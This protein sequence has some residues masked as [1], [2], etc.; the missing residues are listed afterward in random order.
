MGVGSRLGLF[1]GAFD[2]PHNGHVALAKAAID[3]LGLER[4]VVL[5][6]AA[7]GHKDVATDVD[8]RLRLA[9]AAFGGIPGVEVRRE[10]HARTIDT[11]R[12][13]EFA[14]ATFLVGADEFADFRD[15]KDPDE[16]LEHVRLGVAT[17]PGF[18]RERLDEVLATLRRPDRVTFFD[19]EPV[20]VASR[21]LRRRAAAG[22]SI[23]ADVPPP[24]ASVVRS[25][26][27]YR[28]DG[29]LH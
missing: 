22:E 24:V 18:P 15:W 23:D 10:D 27:L 29:G 25:L 19:I 12:A 5:V 7:P 16:L 4:L 28:R 20:D 17:R 21:E 6:M 14:D 9:V 13:G 11:V 26:G 2:P 1:G 3:Q 8:T